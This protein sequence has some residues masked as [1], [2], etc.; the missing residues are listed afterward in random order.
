MSVPDESPASG[1][2]IPFERAA[3]SSFLMGKLYCS[4]QVESGKCDT[5]APH[6]SSI[7]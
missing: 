2:S 7:F 4:G 6:D 1:I 5:I 3:T